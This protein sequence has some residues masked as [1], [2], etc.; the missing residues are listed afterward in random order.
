[1][2][3]TAIFGMLFM[4]AAI[5]VSASGCY[6]FPEEEEILDPPTIDVAE[7]VYS[8]YTA[9]IKDIT[10]QTIT[11][12]YLSSKVQEDCAFTKYT[13]QLKTIYV[14]SGD[15][16]EEGQLLAEM[17][18]GA[19]AYELEVQKLK[20]QLAELNYQNS[21]LAT[22]KLTYEIEKNTL[23]QYQDEYDGGKI[24]A[25][26]SGQ[27]SYVNNLTPGTSVDPYNTIV[28][29]VD[30]EQLY[31]EATTDSNKYEL[32]AEVKIT[33]DD[34]DYTGVITANPQ[35]E[36]ESGAIV[37]N[38]ITADFTSE[39]PSFAYLGS[40]ADVTVISAQKSQVIVIPKHLVK[41][42]ESG[43]N[44]VQILKNDEK[45]ETDVELGIS[46]ATEVEIV[47]GLSEG[48]QVVVK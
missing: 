2:K 46:N 14:K 33:I 35:S 37:S 40:I 19:I 18:N 13:G 43:R 24:Y 22:D 32:G 7:V 15:M 21:G 38:R 16:V 11:S 42:D 25:P 1:M 34:I 3:K 26:I 36:K 12:G 9:K 44:Y 17:N 10:S 28:S 39:P 4:S 27:V 29:I 30:P 41:T 5:A 45:V 8:T 31:V 48:D 20:V 23:A 6:F 47:S